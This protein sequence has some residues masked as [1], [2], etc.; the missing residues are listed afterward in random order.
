MNKKWDMDY[1]ALA[2]FWARLKSKDPS[3]Q[4]GAV[5]VRPDKTIASLGYNG[6]PKGIKDSEERLNDRSLKYPRMIH[7]EMNAIIH[8]KEDLK[9]YTLYV[10]PLPTCDR[11]ATF[12]IEHGIKK[13]VVSCRP[14]NGR[15]I[16]EIA[17]ALEMYKEAGVEVMMY[18]GG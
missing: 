7:A 18:P 13:V 2:E 5:I 9:G 1:L 11:C 3:T 16:T 17:L 6:F 4:V 8:A 14:G 10:W 12:I 15:W